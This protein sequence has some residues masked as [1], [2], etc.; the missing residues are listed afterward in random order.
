MSKYEFFCGDIMKNTG[1]SRR[2]DELGRIVI[3][4]EIRDNLNINSLDSLDIYIDNGNIILTK[5]K[6]KDDYIHPVVAFM[7]AI[8]TKNY[9]FLVIDSIEILYSNNNNYHKGMKL[10]KY[11]SDKLN[12]INKIETS[13]RTINELVDNI[14][15]NDDIYSIKLEAFND[16]NIFIVILAPMISKEHKDLLELTN[17]FV[18]NIFN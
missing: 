2:I 9:S 10:N 11:F 12:S 15:L 13:H 8:N 16:N 18:N 14:N 3:P 7:N 17:C 5:M 1:I 4:K 6:N